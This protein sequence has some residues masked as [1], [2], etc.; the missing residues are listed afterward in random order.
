MPPCS[1]EALRIREHCDSRVQTEI[2]EGVTYGCKRLD[3]TEEGSG[4]LHWAIID[5]AAPG[6][7]LY[8]TPLDPKAVA[9]GWQYR[10]RR[11]GDVVDKERL[12]VAIN[13]TLFES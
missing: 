5:L 1:A 2:F 13:G 3:A 12:A 7:E 9:G 11:I 4:L 10:L 8:V 6:I